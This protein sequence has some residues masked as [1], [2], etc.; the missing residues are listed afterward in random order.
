MFEN[1]NKK[2][3]INWAPVTE[4][5]DLVYSLEIQEQARMEI[6]SYGGFAVSIDTW[7]NGSWHP[8]TVSYKDYEQYYTE[9]QALGSAVGPSSNKIKAGK[10]SGYPDVQLELN[11]GDNNLHG[12][13][14]GFS[15]VYWSGKAFSYEVGGVVEFLDGSNLGLVDNSNLL[16]NFTKTLS[17]MNLK[18]DFYLG[19]DLSCQRN[20]DDDKFPG[21]RDYVIRY[22]LGNKGD[23]I[24][25]TMSRGTEDC[26]FYPTD[27]I[28]W[29]LGG[30][31]SEELRNQH[32]LW[33][34][35]N[36]YIAVDSTGIPADSIPTPASYSVDKSRVNVEKLKMSM[37]DQTLDN[38][39]ELKGGGSDP[40][41]SS[42][43]YKLKNAASLRWENVTL[44][45]FCTADY[46]Q[47]YDSTHLQNEEG[48]VGTLVPQTAICLEPGQI[49][50]A[51][52]LKQGAGILNAGKLG[53]NL[54]YYRVS[55]D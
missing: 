17:K 36:G 3:S 41:S 15:H 7:R 31:A 45:I 1:E 27:H 50:D 2:A 6:F 35:T 22:A 51:P 49:P 21:T 11:D 12:G 55:V 46:I 26:P 9:I 48:R 37:P 28:Y 33:I 40:G 20:T 32:N 39:W 14:K 23:V 13:T 53:F 29:N 5:K 25:M 34:N 24:S 47:I 18:S 42:N 44:D 54:N 16:K 10:V 30:A 43:T 52:N 38:A 8:L 4:G 19:V